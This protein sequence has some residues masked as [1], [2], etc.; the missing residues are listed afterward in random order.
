MNNY[1]YYLKD[2]DAGDT[3]AEFK[4]RVHFI[5]QIGE[6]AEGIACWEDV[7]VKRYNVTRKIDKVIIK[8][9]YDY[10]KE[11]KQSME[12]KQLELWQ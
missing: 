8:C 4:K 3:Y 7:I 2:Y 11:Y 1:K 10:A 6:T 5:L 12:K 9:T